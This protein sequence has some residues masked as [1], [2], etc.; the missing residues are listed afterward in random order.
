MRVAATGPSGARETHQNRVRGSQRAASSSAERDGRS[1]RPLPRAAARTPAR[2]AW[3]C[4]EYGSGDSGGACPRQGGAPGLGL[5]HLQMTLTRAGQNIKEIYIY[6][7]E[8]IRERHQAGGSR[9]MWPLKGDAAL[10]G[11]AVTRLFPRSRRPV[12]P[13]RGGENSPES[14]RLIRLRLGMGCALPGRLPI[15]ATQWR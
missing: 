2:A 4:V 11:S 14:L 9:G 10:L 12:R 1:S 15:E 5:A 3:T 8:S 6:I 13:A 7:F